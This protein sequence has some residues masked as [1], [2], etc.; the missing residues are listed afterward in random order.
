MVQINYTPWYNKGPLQQAARKKKDQLLHAQ[1]YGLIS[2][3]PN[4]RSD[5]SVT[6]NK[7]MRLASKEFDPNTCHS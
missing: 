1:I 2:L 5:H 6:N 7:L 3:A 4:S